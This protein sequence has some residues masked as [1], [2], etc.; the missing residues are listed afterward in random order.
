MKEIMMA[1]P[2]YDRKSKTYNIA[3]NHHGEEILI[4]HLDRGFVFY[5]KFATK[6]SAIDF[7]N[8]KNKLRLAKNLMEMVTNIPLNKSL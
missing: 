4:G 8:S 6:Q 5:D 1:R 3:V 7:I 2:K